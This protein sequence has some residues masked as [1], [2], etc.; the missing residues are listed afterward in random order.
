MNRLIFVLLL[1][2]GHSSSFSQPL[3]FKIEDERYLSFLNT[4]PGY[5]LLDPNEKLVK[6]E[7]YPNKYAKLNFLNSSNEQFAVPNGTGAVYKLSKTQPNTFERFDA[8]LFHGYNNNALNFIYK[9]TIYSLGGYG[10]W[11]SNG[12]LRYFNTKKAEWELKPIDQFLPITSDDIVDIRMRRGI[13]YTYL[14][15]LD[16]EGLKQQKEK[17]IDSIYA[18]NIVNGVVKKIGKA[19]EQFKQIPKMPISLFS[20]Y[21]ALLISSQ[22]LILLDFEKNEIKKW[23]NI[24]IGDL[25][26]S[27]LGSFRPM[28]Q[29]DSIIYFFNNTSLDSLVIPVNKMKVIGSIYTNED[30]FIFK[31]KLDGQ[32]IYIIIIIVLIT[33][34]IYIIFK[35]RNNQLFLKGNEKEAISIATPLTK[36]TATNQFSNIEIELI[37]LLLSQ[38]E[39]G[40][41]LNVESLN[42][43]L[44][45]T[46]KST[47]VQRKQRS[48]MIASINIKSREILN[49]EEDLILRLKS[50][51]DSRIVS[52]SLQRKYVDRLKGHL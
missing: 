9:D 22:A 17:L 36:E 11:H 19:T 6:F 4:H 49:I 26:L 25:F 39:D 45:V 50:D 31:E 41:K 14:K 28:I 23:E 43:I 46:K 24:K 37:Q 7:F 48:Q 3:S 51:I 12:Q 2:F 16:A 20:N 27:G 35:Q 10:L 44:G 13:V 32:I 42:A 15:K 8:T 33:I 47:D 1:V 38:L 18:L 29:N 52:Y 40:E 34:I 21:G 5:Q 30:R